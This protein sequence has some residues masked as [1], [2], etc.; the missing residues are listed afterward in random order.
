MYHVHLSFV[1]R[2]GVSSSREGSSILLLASCFPT[3]SLIGLITPHD[4]SAGLGLLRV[5]LERWF[6]SKF[7]THG[8]PVLDRTDRGRTKGCIALAPH[9][10]AVPHSVYR[11]RRHHCLMVAGDGCDGC[12]AGRGRESGASRVRRIQDWAF[13]VTFMC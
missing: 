5:Q 13:G 8:S 9:R 11:K 10:T 1:Q 7:G 12:G 3:A 2:S 6:T 4:S